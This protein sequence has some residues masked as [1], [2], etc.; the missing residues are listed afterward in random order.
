M[1][2]TPQ[3]ILNRFVTN[4]FRHIGKHYTILYCTPFL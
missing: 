1:F 2:Y 4:T 3:G